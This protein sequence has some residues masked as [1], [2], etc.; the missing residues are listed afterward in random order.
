MQTVPPNHFQCTNHSAELSSAWGRKHN[1]IKWSWAWQLHVHVLVTASWA[2]S[3]TFHEHWCSWKPHEHAHKGFT[4]TLKTLNH[5]Y[6]FFDI[7][8]IFFYGLGLDL[9]QMAFLM[10]ILRLRLS[11]ME[12]VVI[13]PRTRF[14]NYWNF[15]KYI[16]QKFHKYL[17][18][19]IH[20]LQICQIFNI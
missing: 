6:M 12:K 8:H 4:S 11:D 3:W 5:R 14:V 20:R 15:R 7:F 10:L 19:L 18:L 16:S 1:S 2:C 13:L 17:D 9:S